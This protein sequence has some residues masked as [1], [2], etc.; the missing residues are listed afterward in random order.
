MLESKPM[1]TKAQLEQ[2]KKINFRLMLLGIALSAIG[3]ALLITAVIY[4][5]HTQATD[6]QLLTWQLLLAFG[7]VF[8]VVG[9]IIIAITTTLFLNY[10]RS[11]L[12]EHYK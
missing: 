12:L 2:R 3:V 7:S 5:E 1:F 6:S 9:L 8:L 4:I 11:L 10:N